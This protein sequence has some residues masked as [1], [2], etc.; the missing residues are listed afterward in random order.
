MDIISFGTGAILM[1]FVMG[2]FSS[3]EEVD[4]EEK[5]HSD[6]LAIHSS[7]GKRRVT[8]SCQTCRK[9]KIHVELEPY[10]FEC[11]KCKRL[12]DLR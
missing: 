1:A 6:G 4:E 10:L 8:M 3:D 7:D 11:V 5:T 9:L 2:L 12:V